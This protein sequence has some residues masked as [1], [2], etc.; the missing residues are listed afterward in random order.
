M[1]T[2]A[3]ATCLA[4]CSIFATIAPPPDPPIEFLS[5]AERSGSEID[6]GEADLGQRRVERVGWWV[7]SSVA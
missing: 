3:S 7:N 6:G 2:I 1:P 4:A 5:L